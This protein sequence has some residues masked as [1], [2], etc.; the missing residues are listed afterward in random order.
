MKTYFD[1][2]A[3]TR[4]LAASFVLTFLFVGFIFPMLAGDI[5]SLDTRTNGYDFAEVTTA[6]A[7]YGEAGRLRYALISPTLDTLFPICYA[8]FYAG[9]IYRFAPHERLKLL[10]YVPLIGGLID[11]GENAQVTTMLLQY[12]DISEAQV[13]VANRFTLTKFAFT[14]TSMWLALAAGGW[15][16]GSFGFEKWKSR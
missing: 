2:V 10:A 16:L 9:I 12:P 3:Q 5:E 8:S 6:M 7:G 1:V 13:A 15:G 11:L 4:V 14:N